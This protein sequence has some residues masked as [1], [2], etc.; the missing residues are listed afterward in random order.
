MKTAEQTIHF[1][2]ARELEDVLGR[3]ESHVPLLETTF[4]VRAVV[5]D[6]QIRLDGPAPAVATASACI[7]GLLR[8]RN[9][10]S[11]NRCT[12]LV[13]DGVLYVNANTAGFTVIIQ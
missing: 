5:R 3:Q 8:A 13:V 7:D 4:G 11:F 2:N 9:A 6:L 1:D 10:G 12:T